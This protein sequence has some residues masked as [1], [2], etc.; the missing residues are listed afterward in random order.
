VRIVGHDVAS[1]IFL[2]WAEVGY[3]VERLLDQDLL[4]GA[5]NGV[6]AATPDNPQSR[7]SE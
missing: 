5:A 7:R 3:V 2:V 4:I 1:Q 6:L